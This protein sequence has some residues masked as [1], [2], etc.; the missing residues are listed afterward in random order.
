MVILI[1]AYNL[2]TFTRSNYKSFYDFIQRIEFEILQ[3]IGLTVDEA[4]RFVHK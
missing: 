4:D 1:S 3:N 2:L